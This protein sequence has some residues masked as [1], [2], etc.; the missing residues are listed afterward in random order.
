MTAT[1]DR[2][3]DLNTDTPTMVFDNRASGLYLDDQ[4]T[5][6]P[7]KNIVNYTEVGNLR[8]LALDYSTCC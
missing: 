7:N 3:D 4:L 8:K 1:S 6:E 2:H 5:P